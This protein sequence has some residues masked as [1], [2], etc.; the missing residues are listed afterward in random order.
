MRAELIEV[1]AT[2]LTRFATDLNLS[3]ASAADPAATSTSRSAH[4]ELL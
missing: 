3:D 4:P 1:V 2:E